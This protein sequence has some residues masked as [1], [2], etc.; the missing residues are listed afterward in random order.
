MS[1]V[2]VEEIAKDLLKGI[3]SGIGTKIGAKMF[4][5]IFDQS[6]PSYFTEVYKEIEKIMH[7]EITENTINEINGQVNGTSDWV[8]FAYNPRKDSGA[9]KKE[10]YDL[11]EP[12]VSDLAINMIAVL[13]ENAFAESALAVFIIAAGIH[14][15]LLQELATVDPKV[16]DP[17]ESSY[18]VTIKGYGPNYADHAEKTW[19]T[20]EK[21]RKAQV[22]EVAIESHPIPFPGKPQLIST[23]P[24]S[25]A[26]ISQEKYS[27]MLQILFHVCGQMELMKI[28]KIVQMMHEQVILTL[29]LMRY[30][31]I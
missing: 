7:Q 21:A 28:L 26:I 9:S 20:I 1:A 30:R 19:G 6:V 2:V 3:V 24:A 8:K 23:G 14:F 27:L 11:L 10:L 17:H 4:D 15:S 22:T 12:K 25:G 16:Q 31:K 18:I 29:P 5:K 13:Q